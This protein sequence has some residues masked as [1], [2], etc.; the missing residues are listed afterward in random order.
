MAIKRIS[1][2]YRHP[3]DTKKRLSLPSKIRECMSE[4]MVLVG[5]VFSP[6]IALYPM[7]EW[8]KFEARL[9]MLSQT[10]GV[11]ARR[12]IYSL[13]CE[14]EC[15]SQGRIL[16]PQNLY[17][18]AGFDKNVVI[19]GVGTYA[20]IWDSPKWEE[21]KALQNEPDLLETLARANF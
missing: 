8:E 1:G 19:V 13:L 7:E 21:E 4:T 3:I 20:E 11:R 2:E 16:V 6:C 10:E 18:Y 15:D 12:K 5:S 9:E 17:D 14:I